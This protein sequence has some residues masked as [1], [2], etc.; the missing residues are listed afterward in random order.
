MARWQRRAGKVPSSWGGGERRG[1][2]FASSEKQ[3]QLEGAGAV[4]ERKLHPWT[5]G[6]SIGGGV[7]VRAEG[8]AEEHLGGTN[9]GSVT[10]KE[11]LLS[12]LFLRLFVC[13]CMT[14]LFIYSGS[15]SEIG[16]HIVSRGGGAPC[17]SVLPRFF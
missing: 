1:K 5:L 6:H 12:L 4:P 8:L 2:C 13:V 14:D 16:G 9:P 3:L 11:L 15:V 7:H 10:G 17:Q